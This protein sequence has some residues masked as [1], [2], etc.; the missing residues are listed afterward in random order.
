VWWINGTPADFGLQGEYNNVTIANNTITG[1]NGGAYH[2]YAGIGIYANGEVN[3]LLIANN[4][5][6]GFS[7]RG[8]TINE[9]A[10]DSLTI[11][12]LNVIHNDMYDNTSNDIYIESDAGRIT[13]TD[14]DVSTGNITSD[15]L[16]KSAT[17]F[18][19]QSGS[20]CR[21]AGIDVSA[22]TGGT[23]FHGASLYGAAYDIGAFEY[24]AIGGERF[25]KNR[26]GVM[27]KSRDGRMMIY[28]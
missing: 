28:N 5:I 1:D 21:D 9:H 24:G 14:S 15:P 8:I 26:Q 20:P 25:G 17:D 6:T 16:F 18:H 23:D 7:R 19:L 11:N 22:I 3:N 4:I 27:L 12:G 10:D 13:I 2:G